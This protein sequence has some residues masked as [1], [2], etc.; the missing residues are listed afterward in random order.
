MGKKQHSGL[1]KQPLFVFSKSLCTR[2][3]S[4]PPGSPVVAP[5]SP[6]AVAP[7]A[8]APTPAVVT[9]IAV[10]PALKGEKVILNSQFLL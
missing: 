10:G 7:L 3:G 2:A 1:V 4:D 8:P 5:R 6:V 9:V